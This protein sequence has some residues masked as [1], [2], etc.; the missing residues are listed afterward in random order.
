MHIAL[1]SDMHLQKLAIGAEKAP[2]LVIDNLVA[3]ADELVADA[4]AS[5][6]TERSGYYPGIRAAAPL[7][8]QRLFLAALEAAMLD[9]LEIPGRKLQFSM[10]YYSLVTT[11][12]DKL[13][14]PQRIPHVDSLPGNGL[15]SIHYLFKTNLGG[16]AFYRHRQTGFEYIDESRNETYVKALRRELLGPDAPDPGYIN[17][18]TPLFAQVAKQDAV[19]N[20]VLIYRRNSLH[21]GCIDADFS[22]DANPLTGRLSINGFIDLAP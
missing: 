12:S 11:P 5:A 3:N 14:P 7:S 13:T 2:L 20:R 6:F 19:F 16:T 22:P 1:H 4:A 10:C 8:Y 21:S 15:A 17:G 9:C 18:D